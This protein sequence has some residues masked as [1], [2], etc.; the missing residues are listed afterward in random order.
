MEGLTGPD[1]E[2]VLEVPALIQG[3]HRVAVTVKKNDTL[4]GTANTVYAVSTLDPELEEASTDVSFLKAF[5]AANDAKLVGP[6]TWKVPQLDPI[7]GVPF[8]IEKRRVCLMHRAWPYLLGFLLDCHGLYG[9][10]LVSGRRQHGG[11]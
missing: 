8:G 6:D 9:D 10:A 4:L 2:L 1:G 7:Q 3:P 5:V 11:S